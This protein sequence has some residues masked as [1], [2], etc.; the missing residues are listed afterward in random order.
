MSNRPIAIDAF[1]GSGGLSL[2]IKRAGFDLVAAFDED[3][4][5]L[6]T[7]NKNM[8]GHGF[9]ADAYEL[10][11]ESLRQRAG[12]APGTELDLLAGGPPCQGFSKQKRGAHLGDERNALVLEFLRL[13]QEVQ[14]RAFLMENVSTLAGVRG[15]HLVQQFVSLSRYELTG[16]FYLAADYGVPQTRKRFVLVGIRH[17]VPG[18]FEIPKPTTPVWPTVGSALDGLPEPPDDYSVHSDFPNHQAARVTAANVERFSY[19][20]QGGGWQD[21]PF[22]KRLKCHQLVNIKAGGWPDVYGR[23]CWDGQCPTITGGFDSFTRGRYGH[24]LRDRPLT[25]REAARLQGFPD[26]YVFEGTRHDVRHQIG[27]AVPVTMAEAI[28]S[29]VR[30]AL[31]GRT[32]GPPHTL[33]LFS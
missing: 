19:V 20:P 4:A 16:H 28:S 26:E 18:G 17:D 27:N 25:P 11:G 7:H 29:A 24:P 3:E 12:I 13:L 33:P 5:S 30:D 1:C 23:L 14:P 21:I 2:G 22:E 32:Q 8:P 15:A 6:R 9:L 10:T 31:E